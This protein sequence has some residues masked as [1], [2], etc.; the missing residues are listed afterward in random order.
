[1][2]KKILLF[3]FFSVAFSCLATLPSPY[4][5]AK[6]LPFNPHGWYINGPFLQKII[7]DNNVKVVVEI[8]SWYGLSTRDIAKHL[9][10]DGKVFAIDNWEG[11]P[12]E[13]LSYFDLPNLY[14]Q[15]LS[16]V[17][18]EGLAD[19]IVP[20]KKNSID[21]A[22]SLEV[23][24]DLIYLDAVNE[25]EEVYK[26]LT[27]WFPFVKGH[28]IFCG[29]DWN[30][31]GD[32]PV[33][34]A[35]ELFA[36]ENDLEI[37]VEN[38]WFW[39][40]KERA[41]IYD[42]FLF[43][44]ELEILE[45][46]LNELYEYVDKFV[47]VESKET[48]RGNPKPLFFSENRD[49]FKKFE[50]KI[51]HVVVD[52]HIETDNPW[53]RE[54]FQRNQILKG[55][56]GCDENDIIIISDVDE[57]IRGN[58][59]S[60]FVNAIRHDKKDFIGASLKMYAC[61]LNRYAGEWIGPVAMRYGYLLNSNPEHFRNKRSFANIFYDMGWHF[62]WMGGVEKYISKLEAFSHVD[63]DVPE[64]KDPDRI[65]KEMEMGNFVTIDDSFPR[66]VRENKSFFEE[67]GFIH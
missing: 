10:R 29:D 20:I 36:R 53:I 60:N 15:F 28:G 57:I 52:T 47:L 50:E 6:I 62:T 32:K 9:P 24:P 63:S 18:Y 34:R 48:F 22:Q 38:N 64:R 46:R 7:K 19:K 66:Y 51:I 39:R 59:L 26:N 65:K 21:A 37:I 2:L 42:C 25:F 1:M 11:N 14:N 43:F 41:K 54:G 40:L 35:V 45:I 3:W 8:G 55:L 13:D 4:D 27:L 16:N 58:N 17:I 49:L 56:I 61:Y 44:N 5:T 12:N 67:H 33:K 30:W 31:G 23:I